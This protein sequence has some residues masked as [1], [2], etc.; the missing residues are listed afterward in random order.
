VCMCEG[1]R[2][3][4]SVRLREQVCDVFVFVCVFVIGPSPCTLRSGSFACVHMYVRE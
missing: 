4:G 1:G 3:E 2:E